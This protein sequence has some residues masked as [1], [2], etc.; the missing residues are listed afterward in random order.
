MRGRSPSSEVA[1]PPVGRA[2]SATVTHA[3]QKKD[4]KGKEP[5]DSTVAAT[6]ARSRPRVDGTGGAGGSSCEAGA[7][8]IA[9]DDEEPQW[10]LMPAIA[11]NVMARATAQSLAALECTAK[12]LRGR[13]EAYAKLQVLERHPGV[14]PPPSTT[15]QPASSSVPRQTRYRTRRVTREAASVGSSASSPPEAPPPWSWKRALRAIELCSS[16][17]VVI[18][19]FNKN[20]GSPNHCMASTELL[21]QLETGRASGLPIGMPSD[22]ELRRLAR[23]E[24]LLPSQGTAEEPLPDTQ[25]QTQSQSL[26]DLD[27]GSSCDDEDEE[28]I[29]TAAARHHARQLRKELVATARARLGRGTAVSRCDRDGAGP[30]AWASSDDDGEDRAGVERL[31]TRDPTAPLPLSSIDVESAVAK[32]RAAA[33]L[34]EE[35]Y[36]AACAEEDSPAPCGEF[37]TVVSVLRASSSASDSALLDRLK[38]A[39]ARHD[40]IGIAAAGRQLRAMYHR[41]IGWFGKYNFSCGLQDKLLTMSIEH[42]SERREGEGHAGLGPPSS[43]ARLASF[44]PPPL[45]DDVADISASRLGRHVLVIGGRNGTHDQDSVRA[46]DPAGF[47]GS[48]W[49]KLAPLPSPRSCLATATVSGTAGAEIAA[50][51]GALRYEPHVAT[52]HA[53]AEPDGALGPRYG[54]AAGVL[55]AQEGAGVVAVGGWQ[56]QHDPNMIGLSEALLYDASADAWRRLPDM[57]FPR[58]FCTATSVPCDDGRLHVVGGIAVANG[59]LDPERRLEVFDAGSGRWLS[60]DLEE[61]RHNGDRIVSCR[62]GAASCAMPDGRLLIAG[63]GIFSH[64]PGFGNNG[65]APLATHSPVTASAIAVDPRVR[66]SDATTELEDL[67]NMTWGA[68]ATTVGDSVFVIGGNNTKN[69]NSYP[70]IYTLDARMPKWRYSGAM[71]V[72]RWC[73]GCC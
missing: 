72:G 4:A 36:T 47:L 2:A 33:M 41:M 58:L 12:G 13:T 23:S 30:S 39:T 8:M 69:G 53:G 28:F 9:R 52:H 1:M 10:L 34:R 32:M 55:D 24:R 17:A 67:P 49:I 29:R 48:G 20:W 11:D 60:P 5:A 6:A 31:A 46:W 66:P 38:K 59:S 7:I 54:P 73:F 18:G 19:G 57:R 37:D 70:H 27:L 61:G 43:S 15:A 71:N 68:G 40:V 51:C 50:M 16:S 63:G 3:V 45:G 62:W 21:V 42:G 22:D 14:K 64:V 65:A 26:L 44:A 35:Q 25:T 56:R